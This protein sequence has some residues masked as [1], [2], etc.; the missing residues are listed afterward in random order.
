MLIKQ[1][2]ININ[3]VITSKKRGNA[4][5]QKTD[6]PVHQNVKITLNSIWSKFNS[7][8]N[9][10]KKSLPCARG[11]GICNANDGGVGGKTYEFVSQSLRFA[12][13]QQL[14]LHKGAFFIPINTHTY[15]TGISDNRNHAPCRS[16]DRF[17]AEAPPPPFP[18]AVHSH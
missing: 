13:A 5:N 8:I 2:S 6:A 4:L 14:P 11:G 15:N 17:S 3:A 9:S 10:Y 18:L 7:N 1:E 12:N 16:S